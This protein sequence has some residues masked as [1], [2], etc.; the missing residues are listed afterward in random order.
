MSASQSVI[1][2]LISDENKSFRPRSEYVARVGEATGIGLP[3][4]ARIELA[5]HRLADAGHREAA[6][7]AALQLEALVEHLVSKR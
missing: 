3:V 6:A 5:A 2:N 1:S 7:A 4:T